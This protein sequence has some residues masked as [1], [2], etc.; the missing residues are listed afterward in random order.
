MTLIFDIETDG[1]LADLTKIYCLVIYDTKTQKIMNFASANTPYSGVSY[2]NK[3]GELID[4][5]SRS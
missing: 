5:P 1:L 4:Y 3:Q 2:Y